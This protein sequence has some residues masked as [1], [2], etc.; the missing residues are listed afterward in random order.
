M[1]FSFNSCLIAACLTLPLC[2]AHAQERIYAVSGTVTGINPKIQM[3]EVDTD[4]G[5]TGHFRWIK[6]PGP[7]IDFN[8]TVS[9]DATP[10]DKFTTKGDHAIVYFFGEGDVRTVVALRDLGAG[11][12]EI[13]TGAVVKLN[14]K[15]RTLTIQKAAGAQVSFHLDPKTVADTT[16]G[17]MEDLKFDFNKGDS[18]RVASA[19]VNGSDTALLI[20]P[21]IQ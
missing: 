19:Q 16:N 14:R 8:K 6:T 10:P 5:T 20:V 2:V 4:D 7:A 3:T 9:A 18:I 1:K 21:A 12:V 13:T 15:E 17:V 11:P